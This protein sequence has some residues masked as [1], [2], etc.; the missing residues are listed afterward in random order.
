MQTKQQYE[1]QI[2]DLKL[3]V[4]Q[5]ETYLNQLRQD[6]NNERDVLKEEEKKNEWIEQ[7]Y[8]AQHQKMISKQNKEYKDF[9]KQLEE[10]D[11]TLRELKDAL[12]KRETELKKKEQEFEKE[13]KRV[14]NIGDKNREKQEAIEMLNRETIEAN[15]FAHTAAEWWERK[16][17]LIDIELKNQKQI[18]EQAEKERD[19]AVKAREDF[20]SFMQK[21]D[22]EWKSKEENMRAREKAIEKEYKIIKDQKLDINSRLSMLKSA[23]D[24]IK[25]SLT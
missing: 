4:T 19:I 15:N 14:Y 13:S 16:T 1:K 20:D 2:L 8:M 9:I 24:A 22:D 12:A 6:I 21:K 23:K 17:S 3:Q 5:H 18:T 11:F 10:K 25:K 7:T